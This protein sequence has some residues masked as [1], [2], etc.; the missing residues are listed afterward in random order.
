MAENGMYSPADFA[1]VMNGNNGN[2]QWNN[3][4]WLIWAI[5][6]GRNGGFF[7]NNGE[8]LQAAEINGKL[9]ALSSQIQDN[10]NTNSLAGAIGSNHDFLHGLQNSMNMGFAGTNATI[11]AASMANLMGQKDAQAQM[12]S[13][14]CDIKSNILNQT[15]QLQSQVAQLANGVQTGFAN[16]GFLTQQQT[17][18]LNANNT[19]NTQRIIDHMCA[20]ETQNLRDKL[21]QASQNEQTAYIIS[22]LKTTA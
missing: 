12:A 6:F 22:Q 11:N 10:Q 14:C 21:A 13:C 20:A 7:G 18:E 8:G 15:N 19:A 4:M 17:T 5:L 1:A 9:N 2:N 3:P 16:L